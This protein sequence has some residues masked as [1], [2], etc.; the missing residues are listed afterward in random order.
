MDLIFFLIKILNIFPV[1]SA[2]R[3]RKWNK[4][5]RIYGEQF[6]LT[7]VRIH[8]VFFPSHFS[9]FLFCLMFWIMM[10]FSGKEIIFS[11]VMNLWTKFVNI[12]ELDFT[13]FSQIFSFYSFFVAIWFRNLAYKL[14]MVLCMILEVYFP[15][16]VTI[17]Q[18]GFHVY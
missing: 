7:F 6:C 8:W 13:E 2:K 4:K 9:L 15:S 5:N 1:S 17:L 10:S 16:S 12:F 14:Y 18:V 3:K 11:Y